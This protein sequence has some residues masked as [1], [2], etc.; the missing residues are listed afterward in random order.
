MQGA[1]Q[2]FQCTKLFPTFRAHTEV[3]FDAGQCFIERQT[4]KL[5]LCELADVLLALPAVELLFAGFS[6]EMKKAIDLSGCEGFHKAKVVRM[7]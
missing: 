7:C 3:M 6:D 4:C 2:L 5:L 1:Q